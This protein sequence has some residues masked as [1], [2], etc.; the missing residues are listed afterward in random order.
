MTIRNS[1]ECPLLWLDLGGIDSCA[2][3]LN[4]AATR[5][6]MAGRWT[7]TLAAPTR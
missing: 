4:S 1:I 3:A 5:R 2:R 6:I 7:L